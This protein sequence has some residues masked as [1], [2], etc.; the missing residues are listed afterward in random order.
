MSVKRL[1][2][3]TGYSLVEVLVS[4]VILAIAILPMFAM[5]DMGLNSA[6][7]GSTYDKARALANK[8]LEQ[9]QSLSYGTV[10]TAFPTNAPC[11]WLSSGG[12]LRCEVEDLEVPA[13][14]DPGGE[15]D[16]FRYAI[17]KEYVKPNLNGDGFDPAPTAEGDTGMMQIAVEVSWGGD[18][19]DDV[20]YTATTLKV[21]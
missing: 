15:F 2:E 20:T 9:A 3:E 16:N 1:R 21:R 13:A 18:N 17:R 8:Q 5:F 14:E 7:R 11:E 10:R 6:T 12:R 4:I 19:F